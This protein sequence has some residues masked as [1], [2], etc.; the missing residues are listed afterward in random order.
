MTRT[1]PIK[2][3]KDH[4]ELLPVFSGKAIKA[5]AKKLDKDP[6]SGW[7]TIICGRFGGEC[8]SRHTQCR[9]MRARIAKEVIE[10]VKVSA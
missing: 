5:I 3:F 9:A 1:G 7:E 10:T 6:D 8:S 4:P 2:R